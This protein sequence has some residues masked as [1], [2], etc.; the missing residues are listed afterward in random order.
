MHRTAEELAAALDHVR[1]APR[2]RGTVEL[3]ACRPKE[4]ER[5]ILTSGEL[6]LEVGLVGD[7]W[8]A[9]KRFGGRPPDPDAQITLMNARAI[10]ALA[11]REAWSLAG[12]QL[13]VDFDLS[14]ARVPAGTELAI[15]DAILVVTEAP[16]TGCKKFTA[17]FGSEATRWVNSPAGRA[18]NLRGINARVVQPGTVRIGDEIS[19]EIARRPR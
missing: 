4:G 11:E 10:G 15:G 14:A 17:R 12:D 5:R 2:D 19:L 7:M 18:L 13:Y 8:Y 3:I 6:D 1:A 16:H 9:R